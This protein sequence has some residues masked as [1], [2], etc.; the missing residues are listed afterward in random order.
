MTA[1]F[2]PSFLR[3]NLRSISICT[4]YALIVAE[5]GI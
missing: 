5:G 3:R 4:R 1:A 2:Q